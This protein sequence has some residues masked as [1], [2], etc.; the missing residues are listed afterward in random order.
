MKANPVRCLKTKTLNKIVIE[1]EEREKIID[2]K[3]AR[4]EF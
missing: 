3:K 4:P 1:D 2:T